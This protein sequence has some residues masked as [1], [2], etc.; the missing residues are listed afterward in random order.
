MGEVEGGKKGEEEGTSV[1]VPQK[2]SP[3]STPSREKTDVSENSSPCVR[4][5]T[6]MPQAQQ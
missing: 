2:L 1:L 4:G 5:K 6:T 3:H